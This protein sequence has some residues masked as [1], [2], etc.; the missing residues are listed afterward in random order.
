MNGPPTTRTEANQSDGWRAPKPAPRPAPR[1]V[2][3]LHVFAGFAG[4][5]SNH[6]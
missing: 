5:L 1:S 3:V 2:S 6:D 4:T